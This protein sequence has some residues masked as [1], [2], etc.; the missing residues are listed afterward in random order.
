MAVATTGNVMTSS[1]GSTWTLGATNLAAARNIAFGNGLFVVVRGG[2]AGNN[3]GQI[4]RL[5][6][7]PDGI[8]HTEILGHI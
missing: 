4:N 5:A 2:P 1:D 7:S 8:G 6:T 3:P